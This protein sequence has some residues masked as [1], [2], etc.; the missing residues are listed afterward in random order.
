[1]PT[2]SV[3]IVEINW[4]Q[5]LFS[6]PSR[7]PRG[8]R[9]FSYQTSYVGMMWPP[10]FGT[11]RATMPG[12]F[13]STRKSEIPL[14]FFAVLS[15]RAATITTSARLIRLVN[16]LCPLSTNSSPRASAVVVSA[17]KSVPALGS[18]N[19]MAN[20]SSPRAMRGR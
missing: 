2:R 16:I 18:V 12:D 3:L 1:M 20:V 5:P 4:Y 10:S 6:S 13:G 8:T 9:T 14:C 17:A 15:V 7:L 11:S 19:E